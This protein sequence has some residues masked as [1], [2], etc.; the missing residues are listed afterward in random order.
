MTSP[1]GWIVLAVLTVVVIGGGI[2]GYSATLS[3]PGVA[4]PGLI[5]SA[6]GAFSVQTLVAGQVTKVYVERGSTVAA[7]AP[8]VLLSNGSKRTLVRAPGEGRIISLAAR[9]GEVVEAGSTLASAEWSGTAA[10]RPVALV[11][12]PP[13]TAATVRVGERVDLTVSSVPVTTF[14]MLRGRIVSVDPFVS[15]RRD[16]AAY[17][18]DDSLAESLTADGPA[19]RAV[20]E[21]VAGDTASGYAW[22]TKAGPPSRI[23]SRSVVQA[24]I[25]QPPVHP[26]E[27]VLPR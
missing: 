22:S 25:Q 5:T 10:D 1:R 15:T 26:I 7:G 9:I 16:I 2:W 14:G 6:R 21:L 24:K 27:W 23:D 3:P 19:Q 13:Q 8:V 12:L 4:A 11:Y 18:G 20:V 17:L